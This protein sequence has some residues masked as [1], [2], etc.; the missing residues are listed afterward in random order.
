MYQKQVTFGEAVRRAF[1]SYCKFYG[2]A[3]RSEYWWF[4]LFN[5]I[6]CM[7]LMIGHLISNP[8][9]GMSGT[10]S[11]SFDAFTALYYTWCLIVMLPGLGLSWRRLHDIGKGGGW[12][13]IGLIPIVGGIILIV[14]F[15]K[16]S[17]PIDNRFGPVPNI[18]N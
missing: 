2:R 5:F 11:S 4:F 7:T 9:I 17:E 8:Y 10:N 15:C 6:I 18:V 14:W 16:D 1:S 13:F 12:Y 3:S